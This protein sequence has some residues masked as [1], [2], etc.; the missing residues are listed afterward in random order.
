MQHIVCHEDAGPDPRDQLFARDDVAGF[1]R[2]AFEHLHDLG[3]EA[4]LFTA[5]REA[6]K[7]WLDLPVAHPERSHSL[8]IAGVRSRKSH[9]GMIGDR[10]SE[11][12]K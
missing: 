2:E 4:H 9:L 12:E 7:R 5:A 11:P 8:R 6:V 3:L 1:L 10:S